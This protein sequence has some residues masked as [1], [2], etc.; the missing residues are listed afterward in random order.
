MKNIPPTTDQSATFDAYLE[1]Y[2]GD[3]RNI[4][5][6]RRRNTHPLTLDE[7]LGEVNF[8]LISD[9]EKIL[10]KLSDDFTWDNFCRMACRFALNWV[11][12][13]ASNYKLNKEAAHRD[14]TVYYTE[15]GPKST[16]DLVVETLGEIDPNLEELG[17][18]NGAKYFLK[19]LREYSELLTENERL[20]LS[21]MEGG[22]NT[23]EIAEKLDMTHQG[24]S[25]QLQ[26]L[27]KKLRSNVKF[28]YLD[29]SFSSSVD[30]GSTAA[31]N[32][33]NSPRPFPRM[34]PQ[35]QQELHEFLR[36][37]YCVYT[38][39][40]VAEIFKKG[41]FTPNQ[42]L[43]YAWKRGDEY[44][45]KPNIPH[46]DQIVALVKK[47]HTMRWISAV[48]QIP[49][50]ELRGYCLKLISHGLISRLPALGRRPKKPSAK[51]LQILEWASAGISAVDMAPHLEMTVFQVRAKLAWLSRIGLRPQRDR[52]PPFPILNAVMEAH[53]DMS[54]LEGT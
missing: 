21:L 34:T 14:N 53:A 31:S 25:I 6:A 22:K 9:R 43:K 51:D 4:I 41:Q 18:P 20:I 26:R 13:T 44:C 16:F 5:A 49:L 52:T 10:V 2:Q 40:E 46:L 3:L 30:A 29:D 35:D 39:R 33:F 15:D 32:F 1:R 19:F 11:M 27:A 24:V 28:S 48:L 45:L 50:Y 23:Y 36:A 17:R 42:I 7:I 47:K 38:F 12:W 8:R 37:N 54:Q